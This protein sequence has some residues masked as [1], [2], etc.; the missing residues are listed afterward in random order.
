M[1]LSHIRNKLTAFISS[2]AYM[3]FEAMNFTITEDII[4]SLKTSQNSMDSHLIARDKLA[5]I[6][7]IP[8]RIN[9]KKAASH[10]RNLRIAKS[11]HLIQSK[12]APSPA[13][14]SLLSKPFSLAPDSDNPRYIKPG[15]GRKKNS[16]C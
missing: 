4:T 11:K 10:L 12:P 9:L 14:T 13:V 6:E 7:C 16:K 2:P 5:N 8:Y 1:D 15:T 3:I